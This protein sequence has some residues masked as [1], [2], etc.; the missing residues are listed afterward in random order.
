MSKVLDN[1]RAIGAALTESELPSAAELRQIVGGLVYIG[2]EG[3]EVHDDDAVRSAV[4]DLR[5]LQV[6]ESQQIAA[7]ATVVPGSETVDPQT[8]QRI[9]ELESTNRRILAL[10][11]QQA[12]VKAEPEP[13]TGETP[14]PA[15][16]PGGEPQSANGLEVASAPVEPAPAEQP[17]VE[18][19]A[20]P[21]P[22]AI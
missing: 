9:A 1:L 5:K 8:D 12:G 7:E 2:A 18:P 14:T 20:E 4:T 6:P 11:E 21:S 19:P 17:A 3:V 10:L 22:P 16:A 15:P 13:P